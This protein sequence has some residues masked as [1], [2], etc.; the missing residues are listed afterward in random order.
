MQFVIVTNGSYKTKK[1]WQELASILNERDHI[2]FSID[3]WDQQSNNMY[4]INCDWESIMDGIDVLQNT[5]AYKTWATIAFKFNEQH[6]EK[7]KSIAK[8]KKFDA[9]QLTLSTKF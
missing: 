8:D 1:W 5:S 7:I 4:R 6:I 3:G 9:F 2:H